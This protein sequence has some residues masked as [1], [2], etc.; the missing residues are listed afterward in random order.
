[1]VFLVYWAKVAEIL[2]LNKEVQTGRR[3]FIPKREERKYTTTV[4][5]WTYEAEKTLPESFFTQFKTASGVSTTF[6]WQHA[7]LI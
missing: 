6:R 2:G 7:L 3:H 4:D 5:E 1:M